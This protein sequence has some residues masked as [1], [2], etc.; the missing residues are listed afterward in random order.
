MDKQV[1]DDILEEVSLIVEDLFELGFYEEGD[2]GQRLNTVRHK[3]IEEKHR[4]DEPPR[5]APIR[6]LGQGREMMTDEEFQQWIRNE[7]GA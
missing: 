7:R 6:P 1:L 4:S 5:P 2:V 3:L